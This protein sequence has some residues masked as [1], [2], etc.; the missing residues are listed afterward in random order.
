MW[1]VPPD[2]SF[3]S[4]AAFVETTLQYR[5]CY[6]GDDPKLWDVSA[7]CKKSTE[8]FYDG[9]TGCATC[10]TTVYT[11][12]AE[13]QYCAQFVTPAPRKSAPPLP[14][15]G[16]VEPVATSPPPLF[17][18][19]EIDG[20]PMSAEYDE[21]HEGHGH[22]GHDHEEGQEGDAKAP[23]EG[24]GEEEGVDSP[25]SGSGA[26]AAGA[27]VTSLAFGFMMAL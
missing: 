25:S 7:T 15:V 3:A 4:D 6:E 19:S 13:S 10:G 24:E 16:A 18:R 8:D 12:Y 17:P 20:S 27:V 9:M 11:L 14:S 5:E 23:S 22:E 2:S 26:V 21:E 1:C